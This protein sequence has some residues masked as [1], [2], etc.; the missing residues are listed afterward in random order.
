MDFAFE[1]IIYIGC[2]ERQGYSFFFF[3]EFITLTENFESALYLAF[4][5]SIAGPKV[6]ETTRT[7]QRYRS[8]ELSD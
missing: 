6:E 3:E 7:I 8:F 5:D 4:D 2:L 1:S